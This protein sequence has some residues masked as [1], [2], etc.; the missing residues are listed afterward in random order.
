MKIEVTEEMRELVREFSD[1]D[2][3]RFRMTQAATFKEA[4]E[5]T[6]YTAI[7]L[8]RLVSAAVEGAGKERA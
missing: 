1:W 6:R 5:A 4:N 8:A 2:A 3:R 7:R